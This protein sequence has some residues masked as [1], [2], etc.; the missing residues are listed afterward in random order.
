MGHCINAEYFNTAQ[1][2][3]KANITIF[4]AEIASTVNEILL[5]EYMLNTCKKQHRLYYLNEFL[6]QVRTTIFRQTLFSEFE[7][8]VHSQIE[9]E[10]PVTFED[11]NAKYYEL[12]KK[13]YGNS[14]ILPKNLQYEWSRI[15]HFYNSFYVYSYSTGLITAI[16]I[17]NRLLKDESFKDKYINFLKNGT[18]KPAVEILKE[19]GID[20]TTN[21]PFEEAFDFIKNRLNEYKNELKCK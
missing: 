5:N 13:Y 6:D 19:I 11:L 2:S 20:L 10:N 8:Y 4:S 9:N 14:C 7:T 1:P 12:C 18:A 16:C 15:P 3:E 17:A 21:K